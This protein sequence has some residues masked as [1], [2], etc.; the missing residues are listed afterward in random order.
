MFADSLLDTQPSAARR[1]TTL[2]SYAA[3]LAAVGVLVVAPLIYTSGLPPVRFVSP[4]L[5]VPLSGS[6]EPRPSAPTSAQPARSSSI[7]QPTDGQIRVPSRIPNHVASGPDVVQPNA[8]TV[9]G[10]IGSGMQ[11]P[12]VPG[13]IISMMPA[14]PPPPAPPSHSVPERPLVVSSLKL[15]DAISQPKPQYPPM[16]RAAH[17]EGAVVL[18]AVIARDGSI[19]RLHVVSGHP[20]LA[21]AA[22]DAVRQWR[23]R[24]Y[25][26]NGASVE[27]ETQIT[28]VFRM[29][30]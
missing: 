10:P 13:G 8:A 14:P 30:H 28:V 17:I 26:L 16:A 21:Q 23:Y 24:P 5:H 25:I 1:W 4:L 6:Y 2:V 15:A 18:S 19:E 29:E 9:V 3:E 22:L 27:M 7:V 11:G 20:W 12:G